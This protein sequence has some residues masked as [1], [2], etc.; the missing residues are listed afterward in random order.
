MPRG[1]NIG[2][3]FQTSAKARGIGGVSRHVV[4]YIICIFADQ[5][6]FLL[7]DV[8]GKTPL[9]WAASSGGAAEARY[10]LHSQRNSTNSKITFTYLPRKKKR[11]NFSDKFVDPAKTVKVLMDSAPNVLN[12][13]DYEGRLALHLGTRK[14]DVG[15]HDGFW[16]MAITCA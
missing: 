8:E 13:Q 15:N 4:S 7:S 6:F 14:L 2:D 3:C 11:P 10:V 1:S 16:E 9:H 5:I 12:W